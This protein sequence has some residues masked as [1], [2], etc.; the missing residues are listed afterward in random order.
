MLNPSVDNEKSRR[1]GTPAG[2]RPRRLTRQRAA[3][4]GRAALYLVIRRLEL[5][6]STGGA[7]FQF[8]ACP[9]TV[10]SYGSKLGKQGACRVNPAF[11]IIF[12]GT[13]GV[14]AGPGSVASGD[15]GPIAMDRCRRKR[16]LYFV[17]ASSGSRRRIKVT[18]K[19][20]KR[21]VKQAPPS[22]EAEE[23]GTPFKSPLA[24]E[25]VAEADLGVRP[26]TGFPIVGIGASAGGAGGV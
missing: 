17:G 26:T 16:C 13:F 6:Q 11:G 21:S 24:A 15:F 14:I 22:L 2:I 25:P 5:I 8:T 12:L 9:L 10:V 18:R 19:R 3:R 7:A 23:R 20:E 4:Y 1:D